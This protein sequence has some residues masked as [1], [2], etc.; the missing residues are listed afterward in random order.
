MQKDIENVRIK[1]YIKNPKKNGYKSL[2]LIVK[3]PIY[4]TL[5]KVNRKNWW[6]YSFGPLRWITGLC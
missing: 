2:H 1:D 5:R 4:S 6:K 3:V